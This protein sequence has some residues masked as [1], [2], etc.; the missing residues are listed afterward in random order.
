MS[1]YIGP[2]PIHAGDDAFVGLASE[3]GTDF[4]KRAAEHDRDNT[5][6]H[7]NYEALR[8]AGYLRLAV[9]EELGG[10]GAS[11]RQVCYAQ[12]ELARHCSSTALAANMHLY[13]TLLQ[14]FRR[15]GGAPDAEA[16]LRRAVDDDLVLMTSGGSDW[17]WPTGEAVEV[18][19]GYRV[20]GRKTFCSQAPVADV[21][22]TSAP[23]RHPDGSVEVLMF[24]VP[25]SS[26]GVRIVETWDSLGMR[27]TASEDV[28]LEEVFVPTERI[29]AR[30]AW[31]T[32]DA[33][34]LAA[35]AHIAPTSA[36]VYWGVA[37]AARDEAVR[38]VSKRKRGD[39]PMSEIPSVQRMVGLM[40][41]KLEVSWWALSGSLEV[42]GEGYKCDPPTVARIMHGKRSVVEEAV[43]V[44]DLAME[45]V[46]GA[47]F[48]RS[49][50]L[51]RLYRDARAGK[52][53]PLTPEATLTFAGRLA[54]GQP[55]DTE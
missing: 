44:T 37:R 20:S 42:F 25:M 23:L 2:T 30:R 32:L 31:N 53:H 43:A 36:S 21:L 10:L 49:V 52:F 24:G 41:H 27:A 11:I 22:T 33:P 3:L 28:E 8:D 45:V 1:D 47:S 17:L 4:A 48:Y 6:V 13:I 7:E 34:L 46:G 35:G 16:V 40:D 15:R 38:I 19:G 29:S 12:A 9:P 54:L 18:E 14:A 39:T 50:P 51:E 55:V 26:E 5:F